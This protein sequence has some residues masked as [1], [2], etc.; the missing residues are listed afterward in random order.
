MRPR[1]EFKHDQEYNEYLKIYFT[2]LA[3]Q[4]MVANTGTYGNGNDCGSIAKRSV[5]A[6]D[7]TIKA[8]NEREDENE[9]L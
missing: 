3:M 1:H 2:G 6:A 4:G 7:A 5:E 8:L 9:N